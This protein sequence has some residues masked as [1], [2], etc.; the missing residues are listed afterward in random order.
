MCRK[1]CRQVPWF[2]AH[3]QAGCQSLVVHITSLPRGDVQKAC[4]IHVPH[5]SASSQL[6]LQFRFCRFTQ[7]TYCS[8]SGRMQSSSELVELRSE[9]AELKEQ[10]KGTTDQAEKTALITLLAAMRQKEVLLMQGEQA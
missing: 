6:R 5:A 9:I 2:G 3:D 10:L 7:S 1:G 8:R 4:H